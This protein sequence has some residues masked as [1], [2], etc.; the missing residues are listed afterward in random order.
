MRSIIAT[1][2]ETA[3]AIY[4]LC[5]RLTVLASTDKDLSHSMQSEQDYCN[6]T[7]VSSKP[8]N[9]VLYCHSL[10]VRS[11]FCSA[12]MKLLPYLARSCTVLHACISQSKSGSSLLRSQSANQSW[13]A[14]RKYTSRSQ[15]VQRIIQGYALWIIHCVRRIHYWNKIQLIKNEHLK[16]DV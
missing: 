1:E 8:K 4:Y 9:T 6:K 2:S 12:T 13:H 11:Q 7:Q 15:E 5:W 16:G 3:L 14:H 10:E